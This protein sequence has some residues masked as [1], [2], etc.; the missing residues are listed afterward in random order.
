MEQQKGPLPNEPGRRYAAGKV[1][2]RAG[3]DVRPQPAP[4]IAPSSAIPVPQHKHLDVKPS[5]TQLHKTRTVS[6]AKPALPRPHKSLVLKR[7]I[8]ERAVQ[9]KKDVRRTHKRQLFK[10]FVG[11]I[12][13]GAFAVASWAFWDFLPVLRSVSLPFMHNSQT[14]TPELNTHKMSSSSLDESKPRPSEMMNY[15]AAGDA[16]RILRIPKLDLEARVKRVG[17]SLNGEPISPSNIFDVGWFDE[18]GKPGQA[19]TM[20]INGHI[21]G[22]TKNGAFHD[23][24]SLAQNDKIQ[25]ERG[26]KVVI[27]YVVVRVQTYSGDQVDMN[28]ATQSIIPGKNGLNLLTSA[29]NYDGGPSYSDQRVIV[30]AVQE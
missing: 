4:V 21:A 22:A 26:D 19:G 20:L 15:Q 17:S 14:Q 18:S 23:L 1:R 3:A 9:H 25:L 28:T 7:H 8:V 16:P 29:A 27:T 12:I 24:V 30:F 10:L 2:S 13:V 5:I 11:L 6:G